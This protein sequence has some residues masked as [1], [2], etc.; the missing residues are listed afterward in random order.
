MSK[1]AHGVWVDIDDGICLV[2]NG[3]GEL[4]ITSYHRLAIIA[5]GNIEMH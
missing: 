4:I 3:F 5:V 1:A 2:D